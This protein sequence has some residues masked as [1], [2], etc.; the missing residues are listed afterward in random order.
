MLWAYC[1]L[2]RNVD[3]LSMRHLSASIK[4]LPVEQ[5]LNLKRFAALCALFLLA[6]PALEAAPRKLHPGTVKCTLIR[7]RPKIR[8]DRYDCEVITYKNGSSEVFA[9]NGY[10]L[11]F[12]TKVARPYTIL[13][14]NPIII[15]KWKDF[16]LQIEGLVEFWR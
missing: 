6:S 2:V 7:Y 9:A 12:P 4:I 1:L 10:S 5:A 16:T 15:N 8:V 3:D 11:K 14:T 13:N